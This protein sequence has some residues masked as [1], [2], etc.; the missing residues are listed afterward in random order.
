MRIAEHPARVD[1]SSATELGARKALGQV[2]PVLVA[3]LP[4]GWALG[5]ATAAAP[6]GGL[7]GWAGGPLLVSGAAHFALLSVYASG[8][9]AAAAIAT[10]L[11]I[12]SRGLIYSAALSE[13]FASQPR[14]FRAVAPYLLVD[15][16]FVLADAWYREGVEAQALRRAY[17]IAGSALWVTWVAA[18]SAGMLIGPVIPS[19]WRV[20]LVL[21]ALL[22]AMLKT[23]LTDRAAAVA[24]G[25]AAAI[26]TAS[27]ALPDGL[28]I[29]FGAVGGAVA[30]G[31]SEGS[32][33]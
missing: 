7:A 23:A 12:S 24:A 6:I 31:W 26:A 5:V 1:R 14:W 19:S 33:R 29:V 18:I 28:G 4:L 10:A 17:L 11:A 25:T 2:A 30:A 3:L 15:Q 9:G 22:V 13:P 27:T 20:D 21:G 16:V 8:A 32:S